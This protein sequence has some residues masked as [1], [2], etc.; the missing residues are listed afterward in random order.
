MEKHI[1]KI[2]RCQSFDLITLGIKITVIITLHL[3]SSEC[4]QHSIISRIYQRRDMIGAPRAL[5]SRG[6]SGNGVTPEKQVTITDVEY[7]SFAGRS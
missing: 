5:P 1:Y 7:S 2:T 4:T 3:S 6:S